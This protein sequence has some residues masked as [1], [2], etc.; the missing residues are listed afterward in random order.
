[1]SHRPIGIASDSQTETDL[2]NAQPALH[3]TDQTLQSYGLGKLDD[4]SADSVN[5]HL[6]SC[7]DCRS[8]VAAMSS[9]SFLGK[10]RDAQGRPH[11]TGPVVSSLTGMSMTDGGASPPAQPPASTLPPGLADHP[12]Y[13]I[14]REL[15]RGGMGVVYLA[16]NTLMGRKEVLK[17]VG[18]HLLSRPGVLDRFHREIR[19]AAK[20]H[21]PNI[22]A[23]YSA[24]RLGESLVLA[25]EYVEGLDL[26]RMVKAKGL[27]PVAHA[28]NFIYQ[29]ALGLQH[30]H[31]RGMV[32]RDIKPANL[33]LSRDG[34]KPIVK[35]LDFGLAK[36]TSEGQVDNTLTREGQMLGTPDYIA[37]EQIRD[38]QSADIRADIYS[39]GCTLYYL[40]SGGPPFGGDN[41]WDLYQAHF[42]MDAG[43]LNLE[44]PEVP[45]E[46][47]AIAAKMMAKEPARRFQTPGEVAQVLVPFFKQSARTP[48]SS[49][50]MSR[51]KSQVTPSQN[52]GIDPT[53]TQPATPGPAPAERR[54]P[55]TGAEWVAWES[56]IEFKE[57]E[58][59]IE[60]VKP[61][62]AESKPATADGPARQPPWMSWPLITAASVFGLILLGI[63]ITITN[64]GVTTKVTVNDPKASVKVDTGDTRLEITPAAEVRSAAKQIEQSDRSIEPDASA[65]SP[66]SITKSLG[67]A[68]KLIPSGVFL[69]G[70]PYQD[71]PHPSGDPKYNPNNKPQHSVRIT[72]PFYLS[73]YEFTQGQYEKVTGKNPSAFRDNPDLPVDSVSWFDAVTCCN[74][75][76][77]LES[78]SP[79][80]KITGGVVTILGGGGYRLPTEAE[81]EYACRAGTTTRYSFGD[82]GSKLS[83]YV[84]SRATSGS[85]THPVGQKLPN[86]FGLY[87]MNGNVSEWCWDWFDANYYAS[88]VTNDPTG[89]AEGVDRIVRGGSCIWINKGVFSPD[90]RSRNVNVRKPWLIDKEIGFRVARTTISER[91]ENSANSPI[92]AVESPA[93]SPLDKSTV[94]SAQVGARESIEGFRSLFNGKDLTGWRSHP[95]H[96][97]NWQVEEGVLV[98]GPGSNYFLFT[99]REYSNFVLRFQFQIEE[100]TT[101]AVALWGLPDDVPLWVFLDRNRE[102][103]AALSFANNNG[104]GF[105][106]HRLKPNPELRPEGAWNDMEIEVGEESIRVSLNGRDLSWEDISQMIKDKNNV[107]ESLKRRSGR[108]G[109]QRSWGKGAIRFQNVMLKDLAGA[110]QI[111]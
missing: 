88:S 27:L 80:Y 100:G 12:D 8:R 110:R 5:Q 19:S 37:P 81:W 86:G 47:A 31:D 60:A 89:P 36:V 48:G 71:P 59:L 73:I 39:L 28:C 21:H 66:R 7:L 35:V 94:P 70:S 49:A 67:M 9:D 4:A 99:D 50:E 76:S 25:M 102:A 24:L 61:K 77:L 95:S 52:P 46:L 74:Q 72:K 98:G 62:P 107:V 91:A 92:H 79:Y 42:S 14:L 16:E 38:A 103:M 55:K 10:L 34:K 54:P 78:R 15:G 109:F 108:I 2:M 93:Q 13:R 101:G 30:A 90:L 40:L 23:A 20:L 58:D 68:M 65:T 57:A 104:K 105:R 51:V 45:A 6:E 32:H 26:S 33:I 84:W 75:L 87:D 64:K 1:V 3:P 29:A 41:L 69:M 63:I 85:R 83:D 11:S 56:L 82:D 17:V 106:V 53:R 96:P 44:R 18:S 97:A 111:P 43:P 22:V